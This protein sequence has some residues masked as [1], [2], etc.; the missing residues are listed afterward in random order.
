MTDLNQ[1]FL[2]GNLV[3][4]PEIRSTSTGKKYINFSIGVNKLRKVNETWESTVDFFPI[5]VWGD[6]VVKLQPRLEK[7]VLV[8]VDGSLRQQKW[9]KDGVKHSGIGIIARKVRVLSKTE[10]A[11]ASQQLMDNEDFEFSETQDL[12]DSQAENDEI[13][14]SEQETGV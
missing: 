5:I 7:G 13:Y 11:A 14:I 4:K 12:Y 10:N 1:L 9:E 6:S 3:S 2:M 8:L